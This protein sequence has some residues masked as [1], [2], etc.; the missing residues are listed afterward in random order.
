MQQQFAAG[1]RFVA[2]AMSLTVSA[3]LQEVGD[4]V[5]LDCAQFVSVV[6]YVLD[7]AIERFSAAD[8]CSLNYQLQKYDEDGDGN[9]DL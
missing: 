8:I 6:Q 2:R 7:H 1:S 9:M 5:E 3:D 4:E